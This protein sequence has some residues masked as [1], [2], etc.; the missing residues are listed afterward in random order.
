MT[1]RRQMSAVEEHLVFLARFLRNP[2]QVGALAPSSQ[3]LARAMAANITFTAESRIVELGPGTGAFTRE[4]IRRLPP[5]GHFLAVD[6]NEHFCREL[7]D[8]WPTLDCECG[9]AADLPAMLARRGWTH[10]DHIVSGLPF[11]SLPAALSR[12]ILDAVQVTLA[13]GGTFTTFQYVHAYPTPPAK[14]FRR[15]MTDR[16]GGMGPRRTV[17][18][19]L[20]PAFVLSW[21]QPGPR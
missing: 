5:G 8:R 1:E 10:A 18:R 17:F 13:P 9:S 2:R 4:I 20:P 19:N 14:A 12:S 11:A 6:I 7:R 15:S 3:T 21:A 16:F